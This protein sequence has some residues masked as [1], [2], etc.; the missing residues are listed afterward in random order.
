MLCQS[1]HESSFSCF[2]CWELTAED[3][4]I[5]QAPILAAIGVSLKVCVVFKKV[6]KLLLKQRKCVCLFNLFYNRFES[7]TQTA[8]TVG[9]V[10]ATDY[11]VLWT[12]GSMSKACFLLLIC[13]YMELIFSLKYTCENLCIG[14]SKVKYHSFSNCCVVSPFNV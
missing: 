12:L 8:I 1:I 10:G 7:L 11:T 6:T 14:S 4:W 9:R 3:K 5:Y 13:Y 2:R